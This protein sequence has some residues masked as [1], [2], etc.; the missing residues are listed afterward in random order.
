MQKDSHKLTIEENHSA[1][2]ILSIPDLTLAPGTTTDIPVTLDNLEGVTKLEFD[3]YYDT[4]FLDV[5]AVNANNNLPT[6]WQL[7]EG[8]IDHDNGIIDVTLEG[9]DVLTGNNL[10]IVNLEAVVPDT[11]NYGETQ[12]L[13]LAN[14]VL[15]DS[16]ISAI[17]DDGIHQVIK[18]GDTTGDGAVTGF[19]AY[20][21]M[22]VSVGLDDG[23]DRFSSI[24]PMISAD[25]NG[26]GVISAFD[27][28]R[29]FNS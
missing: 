5:T 13:N 16:N 23:F 15:N 4:D 10:N 12:I 26:D 27:A 11:A 3:F 19:D 24:D 9:T 6:G 2:R 20:Q 25:V 1:K 29:A 14:V 21:M 28:Y 7:T 18:A 22:R 8:K 17:D